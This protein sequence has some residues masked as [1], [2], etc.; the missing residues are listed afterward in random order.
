[1]ETQK[2]IFFN[3]NLSVSAVMF[4]KQFFLA[5]TVHIDWSS[6]LSNPLTFMWSQHISVLTTWKFMFRQ[7]CIIEPSFF[8]T[9]SG[10]HLRLF[11]GRHLVFKIILA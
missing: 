5:Y 3:A 1:M 11:E 9:T 8:N 7:A 4:C 2:L 6:F 10:M